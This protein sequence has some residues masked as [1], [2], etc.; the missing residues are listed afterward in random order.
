MQAFSVLGPSP[1]TGM[2][3]K[4]CVTWGDAKMS[5][6]ISHYGQEQVHEYRSDHDR[7]IH[8]THAPPIIDPPPPRHRREVEY[9]N[10]FKC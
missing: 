4:D 8:T 2:S 6:L 7:A 10:M 1:I 3:T 9:F 5:S